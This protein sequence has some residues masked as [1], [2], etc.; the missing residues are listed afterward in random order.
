MSPA[1]SKILIN[2]VGALFGNVFNINKDLVKDA[3]GDIYLAIKG[4]SKMSGAQLRAFLAAVPIFI[5]FV[6]VL[7]KNRDKFDA[8]KELMIVGAAAVLTTICSWIVVVV[9]TTTA[10]QVSIAFAMPVVGIP[11]L[12]STTAFVFSVVVF[13]VWIV[14][15]ALNTVFYNNDDFNYI[16]QQF[17][18]DEQRKLF[19]G[20]NNAA[21]G[22]EEKDTDDMKLEKQGKFNPIGELVSRSMVARGEK[23]GQENTGNPEKLVRKLEKIESKSFAGLKERLEKLRNLEEA[24]EKRANEERIRVEAEQKAQEERRLARENATNLIRRIVKRIVFTVVLSA[25]IVAV[26][27][28]IYPERMSNFWTL[29]DSTAETVGIPVRLD[30]R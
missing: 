19:D 4:L 6:I 22:I 17:L 7:I 16:K 10:V 3:R 30:V 14:M 25:L 18:G 5:S 2:I 13:L 26:Y 24:R 9:L 15:F 23:I 21:V 20:V 29:L 1:I 28:A 12:I 8:Q 11:L 27:A